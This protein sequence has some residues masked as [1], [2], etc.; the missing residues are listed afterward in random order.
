MLIFVKW[1][2]ENKVFTFSNLIFTIVY[3]VELIFGIL[4]VIYIHRKGLFVSYF[5]EKRMQLI[6]FLVRFLCRIFKNWQLRTYP[7]EEGLNGKNPSS[8][9]K[10]SLR[11]VLKRRR[12]VEVSL[13]SSDRKNRCNI[14]VFPSHRESNRS[15]QM[16][17]V[18]T[19]VNN[20]CIAIVIIA[21]FQSRQ[22]AKMMLC[23][24]WEY[25]FS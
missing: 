12:I 24:E 3:V 4:F 20:R 7:P 13:A 22:V 11:W 21:F 14:T 1:T 6:I 10:I 9:T 2:L 8:G 23:N 18:T 16:V 19:K 17:L 5:R 25:S 15:Q